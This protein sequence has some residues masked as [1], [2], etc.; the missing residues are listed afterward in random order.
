MF[1]QVKLLKGFPNPLTYSVPT[2]YHADIQVG[3]IVRVPIRNTISAA[4]VLSSCKELAEKPSF[5]IKDIIALEPLPHDPHYSNFIEHLGAYYQVDPLHFIKRIRHFLLQE[6]SDISEVNGVF[7]RVHDRNDGQA[8]PESITLT[9]EQQAVVDFLTPTLHTPT[10]TPTLLHGITG[11]GKTEVYKQLIIRAL[12]AGKTALLL[13]PE[14]TLALQFQK[15]LQAQLPSSVPLYAFHSGVTPKQKQLLWQRLLANE[16][17]LIIGVHLPILLPINNL[18]IIIVDEEHDGGY[19]E[20]KHPK[21]NTKDAALLRAHIANIPI[22]LGS[23]TPSLSSLYNVKTKGWH[24]FELKHRFA[25]S[26][27]TI[28]R[29]LLT[30][31]KQRK[32]FWI[33]QPLEQAIAACLEKKEQCIIFINR[34]G[35]SFFIQCKA[36]AHIITCSHCSVSLTVHEHNTLTCHYCG[37]CIPQPA[38]CPACKQPDFIN[39]GIGTQQVVMI[40]Q[41]MFPHAR[42]GRADLDTTAKKK[43]W[44]ETLHNFEQ[45]ALD[46]LVG[47]QT[48]TKGF[49]FPNVT[50]VGI[51][52]ADLNVHFPIYNATETALQQLIQ[53]AGRA[54]RMRSDSRVIVQAMK[55][56]TLFNYLQETEYL[57]FYEQEMATR[58]DVGYPPY[59]RLVELELKYTHEAT[60]EIEAQRMVEQLIAAMQEM[61]LSITV[62]G[63]AKPPVHM[64]KKIYMRK[65]YIKSSSMRTIIA[66]YQTINHTSYKSQIFFTPNPVH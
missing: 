9:P 22:L 53:V 56:H 58:A 27:P 33:S 23:A 14:V 51:I 45:G 47:T 44:Q 50:L 10:Y 43:L 40:L 6:T 31:K 29:V 38:H 25:G 18:G 15:L 4:V 48:I 62:L 21:I 16:P 55:D 11:S 60:V 7:V 46:I 24:F 28:T 34:R 54:G 35:F 52:W 20:K 66:A 59:L 19:Q 5:A 49:H 39:K 57:H 65:I 17:M 26:L 2:Q 42:I 3:R 41:K 30:D 61:K 1:I 37:F 64:I 12:A 8:G 32:N 63:P 13:L 36:C